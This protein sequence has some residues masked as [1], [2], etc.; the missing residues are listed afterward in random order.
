M[1]SRM[2][3]IDL[4]KRSNQAAFIAVL[5]GHQPFGTVATKLKF[6]NRFSL[7]YAS[8]SA[9]SHTRFV[10]PDS[11]TAVMRRRFVNAA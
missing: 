4:M 5:N 2:A 1:A 7:F 11:I 9:I 8:G 10:S 6:S 3:R